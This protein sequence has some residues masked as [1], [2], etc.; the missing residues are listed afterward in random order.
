MATEMTRAWS[1]RPGV[2]GAA[3]AALRNVLGA[4]V[5]TWAMMFAVPAA[6]AQNETGW[7]E[8]E[9]E[10][11][12]GLHKEEWYDPTDWFD[13]HEGVEYESDWWDYG[14]SRRDYAGDYGSDWDDYEGD[15]I[16]TRS[17]Y[18]YGHYD[19]GWHYDRVQNDWDYGRH[20]DYYTD[21]WYDDEGDFSTWYD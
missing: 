20:F 11:D 3:P 17:G 10:Y 18:D 6:S 7:D 9:Y 12:E 1:R 19:Y 14:D 8:Y 2:F 21:D 13:D 5:L 15:N 4:G 16:G